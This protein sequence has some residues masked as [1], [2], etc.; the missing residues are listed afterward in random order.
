VVKLT[1]ILLVTQAILFSSSAY[2]QSQ[3]PLSTCDI[4]SRASEFDGKFVTL[5][6]TVQTRFE[7]FAIATADTKCL[8]W[9]SYPGGGPDASVNVGGLTPAIA[10]P[11]VALKVDRAFKHFRKLLDATMFS[12]DRGNICMDCRRYEVTA[13]MTG[14]IDAAEPG[15]GFGHLNGY[16]VRFVLQQVTDVAAKDL[17]GSYD[18]TRFSAAPVRLP[19]AYFVGKVFSPEGKPVEG[20]E[21]T[22][23][24]SEEVPPYLE[25]FTEWTD[26]KGR[27][28]IE[29]PPGRY[30]VGI[31]L[32]FPPSPKYPYETTYSPD[33][34]D[35]AKARQVLVKDRQRTNMSIRVPERMASRKIPVKV[36]WPDGKPVQNAN[37]W[38]A[39]QRNPTSV[40]GNSV[41]HTNTT[42]EFELQG[43]R[44]I[45]Y[46]LHANIY[47]KPGFK[48]FCAEKQKIGEADSPTEPILMILA[49]SGDVCRKRD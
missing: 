34:A 6:A 29:V 8:L 23:L 26:E 41:S 21:V 3:K 12:R 14:R 7:V 5:R 1:I 38:L 30:V 4:Q 2:P 11:A 10:R 46:F 20:I 9:L 31:N 39:E 17:A 49:V 27:F 37:V 43:F 40:V 15:K 18:L 36:R 13:T 45:P 22:A 25:D 48:P 16:P 28:K 44:G 19:T 35:R 24:S 47:V 32:T 42:G 33:T